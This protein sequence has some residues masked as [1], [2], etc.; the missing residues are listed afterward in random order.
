MDVYGKEPKNKNG[1]YFRNNIW[2]W[3][4][5]WD[6]CC[7]V[8]G[9][10][11]DDDLAT[12]GHTNDGQG[13][14]ADGA[15]RLAERLLQEVESGNTAEFKKNYDAE[16][17]ALPLLPCQYCEETGIRTDAVGVSGGMLTRELSEEIAILLGRTHGTCNGCNGSGKRE[18]FAT[19]Y[20]FEVENVVEFANF[21]KDSGG[22]EI[23]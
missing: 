8:A 18:S 5:L 9:D 10:V 4:P 16:L 21:C 3:R 17:A 22:F 19:S 23:C 12:Y 6:Y 14:D 7:D 11:I 20:P 1:E 13:L 15:V 2:Y